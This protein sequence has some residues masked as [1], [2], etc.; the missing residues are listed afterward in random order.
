MGYVSSLNWY[1]PSFS[2]TVEVGHPSVEAGLRYLSTL[3][4]NSKTEIES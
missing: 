1:S 4:S 2:I 3:H